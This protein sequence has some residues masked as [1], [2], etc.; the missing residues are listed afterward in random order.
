MS[1]AAGA[2]FA[3]DVKGNCAEQDQTLDHLL[4]GDVDA[5][6]GHAVVQHTDRQA[7][8]D[9]ADDPADPAGDSGAADERRGD[10]VEFER[11]CRWSGSPG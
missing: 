10:G 11:R 4:V 1:S 8:D 2:A 3:V 9:G 7:T 6:D 5:E